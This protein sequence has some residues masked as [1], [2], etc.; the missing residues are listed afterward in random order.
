MWLRYPPPPNHRHS[1]PHPFCAH[2]RSPPPPHT[3][4]LCE[5]VW[6]S[7]AIDCYIVPDRLDCATSQQTRGGMGGGGKRGF[8]GNVCFSVSNLVQPEELHTP[9]CLKHTIHD[10]L[11]YMITH[12]CPLA[13]SPL[14]PKHAHTCK[15]THTR[16]TCSH[17]LKQTHRLSVNPRRQT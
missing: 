13:S 15:Q 11:T 5:C 2:S 10:G 4:T 12:T 9:L 1:P 8:L 7:P 14:A 17:C 3:H 16:V 6:S